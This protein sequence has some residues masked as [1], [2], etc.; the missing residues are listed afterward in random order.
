MLPRERTATE[1]N[2]LDKLF[3][4]KKESLVV[5]AY[6]T[7][8][9]PFDLPVNPP[10]KKPA[11]T[12]PAGTTM[13]V[14]RVS[15]MGDFAVTTDLAEPYQHQVRLPFYSDI[16][17]ELRI[18]KERVCPTCNGESF[19]EIDFDKPVGSFNNCPSCGRN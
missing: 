1:E 11:V 12:T 4:A 6:I 16:W 8:T 3:K 10:A 15:V 13:R 7:T 5:E 9:R 18:I 17:S 19:R 2:L 14:V